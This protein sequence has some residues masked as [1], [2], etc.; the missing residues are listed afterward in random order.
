MRAAAWCWFI[1]PPEK[2][3]SDNETIAH[4]E[5]ALKKAKADKIAKV[6]QWV[7]EERRIAEAKVA[8]ERRV[9]EARVAEERQAAEVK[10]REE[11]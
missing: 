4:M 1:F 10:V 11:E 3:S 5:A 7:A 2:M 8:E 6:E 9:A